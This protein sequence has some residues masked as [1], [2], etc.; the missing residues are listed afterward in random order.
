MTTHAYAY[1]RVSTIDQ[2]TEGVSLDAQ[3]EKAKRYCEAKGFELAGHF[4]DAGI[5]GKSM[6]NRPGLNSALDAVCRDRGSVLV[7]Y[8]LSRLARSTR[9]AI[10]IAE[11]LSKCH[12]E[13]VSLSEQIDTTTAA[14]EMMFQMLAVLAQFERKLASERT[15]MALAHKKSKGERTG[16]VPFGSSLAPDGIRLLEDSSETETIRRIRAMRANGT[17][18]DSIARELNVTGR[19]SKFGQPWTWQTARKVGIRAENGGK[20]AGLNRARRNPA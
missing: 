8:S 14:G 18:W 12:G 9:D 7:V 20:A 13:L 3:I 19:K 15:R 6:R 11:R 10:D 1:T 4:E 2:A 16:G 5:S 17:G